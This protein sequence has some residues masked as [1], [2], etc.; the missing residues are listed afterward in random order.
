MSTE[1]KSKLIGRDISKEDRGSNPR[2]PDALAH[3]N[4]GSSRQIQSKTR[5]KKKKQQQQPLF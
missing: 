3:L 2:L 4:Q 5:K 1:E